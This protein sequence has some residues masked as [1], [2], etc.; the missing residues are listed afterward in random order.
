MSSVL[1]VNGRFINHIDE[2][3][4][5]FSQTIEPTSA[6]AYEIHDAYCSGAFHSWLMERS[7]DEERQLAGQLS[8]VENISNSEVITVLSRLFANSCLTIKK[9]SFTQY[10][11]IAK[12]SY[13]EGDNQWTEVTT[14]ENH[15]LQEGI[16][17]TFKI[18]FKLFEKVNEKYTVS[19]KYT[20]LCNISSCSNAVDLSLNL[21]EDEFEV[22]FDPF[23]WSHNI[24]LV[25]ICV[26]QESIRKLA[27]GEMFR[28]LQMQLV[29]G[30]KAYI[31]V[32]GTHLLQYTDISP[33]TLREKVMD[34][35]YIGSY[36]VTCD[37]WKA[38]M[39]GLPEG[40]LF[41][42]LYPIV[43]VTCKDVEDFINKL[44]LLTG[45]SFRLPTEEEWE[46]AARG[47]QKSNMFVY[48]G[49][50]NVH[51]VACCYESGKPNRRPPIGTKKSN[52]LGLYDM[53]GCVWEMC[54]SNVIRGGSYQET[55]YK[56]LVYS[57]D[58]I[59]INS[60]RFDVGFRL[61]MDFK[62]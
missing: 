13:M 23:M 57:R 32:E 43:N 29:Q 27:I 35:F 58:M 62:K 53:S 55:A 26:D 45:K 42:S 33:L 39:G 20:D 44:N 5:I 18:S 6:L 4:S 48:S 38:V 17:Y 49:S 10:A 61:A 24:Y 3:K 46:Y 52:E 14:N 36:P 34:S 60:A 50:N 37:L 11:K 9:P 2:L 56:C 47:G 40:I 25:D 12:F 30:G 1:Y 51:E 19:L 8:I 15:F 59:G 54:D 7:S 41:G 28:S 21:E 22:I 31:G 16:E